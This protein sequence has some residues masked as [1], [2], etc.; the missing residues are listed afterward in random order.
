M[1]CVQ[2]QSLPPSC[3]QIIGLLYTEIQAQAGGD[4]PCGDRVK[5]FADCMSR[6]NGDMGACQPYFEAMQQCKTSFA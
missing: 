3:V 2:Q 4:G 6:F 5:Q 1:W